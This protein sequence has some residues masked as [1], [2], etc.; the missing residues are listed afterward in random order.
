[1]SAIFLLMGFYGLRFTLGPNGF[2]GRNC[3]YKFKFIFQS[4]ICENITQRLWGDFSVDN[5]T[6]N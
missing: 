6:I 1:M 5:V 3:N 2:F 4:L